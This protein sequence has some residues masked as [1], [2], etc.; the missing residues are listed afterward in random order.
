MQLL[1]VFSVTLDYFRLSHLHGE[2]YVHSIVIVN[3]GGM[4]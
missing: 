1:P 3:D 4:G 2:F